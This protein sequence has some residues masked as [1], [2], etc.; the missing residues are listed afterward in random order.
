MKTFSFVFLLLV[1]FN[2]NTKDS[3]DIKLSII[4]KSAKN[5]EINKNLMSID[6]INLLELGL[7]KEKKFKY[8]KK[9]IRHK[10]KNLKRRKN[11]KIYSHKLVFDDAIVLQGMG[12]GKKIKKIKYIYPDLIQFKLDNKNNYNFSLNL[13]GVHLDKNSS[14]G[15][16]FNNSVLKELIDFS[17]YAKKNQ[18][19]KYYIDI[20]LDYFNVMLN[21]HKGGERDGKL[22]QIS[23]FL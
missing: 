22:K 2:I 1:I 10:S 21:F 11:K 4:G 18:P 20:K 17:I 23:M 16:I 19:S 5:I 12:F 14:S 3:Y 8:S 9:R 7:I 13:L 15:D 6:T